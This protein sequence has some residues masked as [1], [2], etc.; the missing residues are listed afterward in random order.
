MGICLN[1][2]TNRKT[3]GS[4]SREQVGGMVVGCSLGGHGQ[5][6]YARLSRIGLAIYFAGAAFTRSFASMR[7]KLYLAV[8]V[9]MLL[10]AGQAYSDAIDAVQFKDEPT[11]LR[12]YHLVDELRCPKCQNQNLA[13]SNSQ[14]AIDLRREVARL[15]QEG[16]SDDEIKSFMVDRYGDFVLY[17]PPLQSNTLVLWWGPVGMLAIGVLVYLLILLSK[18]KQVDDYDSEV[19]VDDDAGALSADGLS[20]DKQKNQNNK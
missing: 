19:L 1:I 7:R 5:P 6:D 11:R 16:G 4:V 8:G 12:F 14:I 13:D 20:D 18:R 9:M 17:R 2:A 3:V 10:L 15:V